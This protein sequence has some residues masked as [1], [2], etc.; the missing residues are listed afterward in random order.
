MNLYMKESILHYVWLNKL[1]YASDLRTTDGECVEVLNVGKL[2][3]D[4]GPDFF[5]AKIKITDTLWAGNVEIHTRSSDWS[6]HKHLINKAY[7]N[8]V[9]HVVADA[10]TEVFRTNG[11]KIPQMVLK[12]PQ[13][14]NENY[15]SL[16]ASQKWI[17][18]EDKINE[19][20]KIFI[21]TWKSA[22][23]AE[24]LAQKTETIQ[25]LL[26][27]SINSWEDAF[28]VTIAQNFGFG[29]NSQAFSLLAKSLPQS[30]LAK[31]KDNLMQ[32]EALLFG[33]SGLLPDNQAD[34]Y[35]SQLKTEYAFLQKKY[36][37]T[38]LEASQWKLLRLRPDN[39]PQVRIAQFAALVQKSSKLFSKVLEN[40]DIKSLRTLF[41][42][43][44]SDFW[45]THYTFE[46]KSAKK[47]KNLSRQT[48]DILLIN[49]V[50]PML[51]A[52][53]EKRKNQSLKDEVLEL[54]EQIPAEKNAVVAH[55]T[56]IGLLSQSA[57]DTQALLQLKNNYC[58]DKKCLHCRIGHKILARK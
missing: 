10:D 56:A 34:N 13:E 40:H 5:N 50:I 8:V 45:T 20:P 36:N 31:H 41:A 4:A 16:L 44:P 47:T 38:P 46:R 35:V 49:T 15:E 6:R 18:C 39:F 9:L 27:N 30:I 17:L 14:I 43:E 58:A 48:I 57:F 26:T 24:R 7:D 55:W 51:F 37:L 11:T 52:Y 19:V 32:I 12:Y 42:C 54:L 29:T 21:N 23:L 1:F 33:Q 28:Y 2:N 25:N 3:T 53:A 22:L